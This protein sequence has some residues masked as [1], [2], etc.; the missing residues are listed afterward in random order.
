M[1]SESSYRLRALRPVSNSL[2]IL[3]ALAV[4]ALGPLVLAAA[5]LLLSALP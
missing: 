1:K 5:I 4:L 2:R 3:V